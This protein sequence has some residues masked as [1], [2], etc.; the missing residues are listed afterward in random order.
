MLKIKGGK[1]Q[2]TRASL[3]FFKKH[4]G[5]LGEIKFIVL[6]YAEREWSLNPELYHQ[7]VNIIGDK[8]QVWLS[9]LSWG[10]YGEGLMHH[11]I[12]V[13]LALLGIVILAFV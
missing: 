11:K 8:A 4:Y 2:P 12:A 5:K 7:Y 10:Y 6:Y 3:E 13:A 1:Y 9:G